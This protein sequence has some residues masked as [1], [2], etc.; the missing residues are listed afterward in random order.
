VAPADAQI[1]RAVIIVEL[2]GPPAESDSF[3]QIKVSASAR[4][5]VTIGLLEVAKRI[6]LK[7][8]GLD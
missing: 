2:I 8:M 3:T 1:G 6:Q 4:P 7:M 5:Y